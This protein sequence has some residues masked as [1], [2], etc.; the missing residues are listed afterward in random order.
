MADVILH[1]YRYSV[2]NR[3]ARLA[4][5]LKG[6]AYDR[7]EVDPFSDISDAYRALH[8]FGKVPTLV[9]AGFALFET[10]AIT[11]YVDRMF[12]GPRLQPESVA[13]LA[14]MDQV[15]AVIDAYAYWPMVRQVASHAYFRP[16]T[17]EPSDADEIAAGLSASRKALSFLDRVAA[18]GHVMNGR[19]VTLADC[20]L[21]PMMDYFVRAA[22]GAAALK[23]HPS[24]QAWWDQI[25]AL[26]AL[27]ACDPFGEAAE[28]PTP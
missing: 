12:D 2:Y 17:G 15:I 27:K 25:S 3:A 7:I 22:P 13:A 28:T 16:L 18:E 20:H 9:H 26:G 1:G 5:I 6:V 14:R 8:P 23:E 21:A 10:G 19:E 11:R 24:L 4:L